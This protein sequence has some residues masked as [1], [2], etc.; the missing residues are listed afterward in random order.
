[1]CVMAEYPWSESLSLPRPGDRTPGSRNTKGPEWDHP[2]LRTANRI[3]TTRQEDEP[4]ARTALPTPD[5][6]T[7]RQQRATGRGLMSIT[8]TRRG[9]GSSSEV[10]FI[11]ARWRC[12]R[13]D[14]CSRRTP[15]PRPR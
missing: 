3:L 5:L 9:H 2:G 13:A 12:R 15:A 7:V 10:D 14:R 8:L 1:M 4:P 6:D 11:M